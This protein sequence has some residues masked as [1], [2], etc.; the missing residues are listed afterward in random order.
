MEGHQ[1]EFLFILSMSMACLFLFLHYVPDSCVN[2]GEW[3]E[4]SFL[5]VRDD[6]RLEGVVALEI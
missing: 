3:S 2:N 1:K 4:G 6:G 5:Q